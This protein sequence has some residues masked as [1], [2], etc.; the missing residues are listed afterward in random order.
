MAE[1]RLSVNP[2][3]DNDIEESITEIVKEIDG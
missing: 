3:I 1:P 2:D